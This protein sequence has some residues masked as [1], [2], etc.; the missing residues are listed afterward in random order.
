MCLSCLS[1]PYNVPLQGKE[2]GDRTLVLLDDMSLVQSHSVFMESL[3]N[4]GH[5][6][7][8][9]KA[10]SPDVSLKKFGEYSYDNIIL[11]APRTSEF[12]TITFDD[13][14]EF[15]D[16]GGN[17][18]F[19][20]DSEMSD[21]MRVFAET[22]GIEFDKKGSEILDH[23]SFDRTM[24][25]SFLHTAV[26]SS[27]FITSSVVLDQFNLINAKAVLYK[28]VGHAVD[29]KN[30]LAVKI[31]RGNPTTYSSD[32]NVVIGEYPENAGADTLLISSVQARNNARITFSGS[33]DF[34]SNKYFG[35]N[36]GNK[37][38]CEDLSKW[39]FAESG[40]LRYRD[41]QHSKSDGV[42]PDVILHE[43][44][45]PDLPI[46]LFPDPEIA[47]NSLVYRIKDEIVFKMVIE[48]YS[49]GKWVPFC[50]KDMQVEF[51]MLDPYIRKTMECADPSTGLHVAKFTSPDNYGIFKFRVMYRR[52][53]YSTLHSETQVS[54]RPF[55]HNEYERFLSSA[56]PYYAA[57]VSSLIA[58]FLFVVIFLFSS[59]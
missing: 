12:S 39:T 37:I 30:V 50:A 6:L 2:G 54:I 33:I 4:R 44:E 29:E 38:F 51:V 14:V 31:L 35:A 56:Y 17:L 40:V 52:P 58:F 15:I 55:K 13:L 46:S 47:R 22:C 20:A 53:G 23:F 10:D 3:A 11:F 21:S 49:G 27:G 36:E 16:D 5:H 48:Q 1:M 43:K 59:D 7:S 26:L 34:F 19:G 57:A 32:P 9:L 24:D 18:L 25:E 28:G 41:I 45:R 8:F 42:P